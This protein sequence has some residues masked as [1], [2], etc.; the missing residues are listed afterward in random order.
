VRPFV[1]E[2]LSSRGP[3]LAR[4]GVEPTLA[5][6]VDSRLRCTA[7]SGFWSEDF[8][9]SVMPATDHQRQYARSVA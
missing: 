3:A 2:L 8:L 7:L 5:G 6:L 4:M 9:P 1:L